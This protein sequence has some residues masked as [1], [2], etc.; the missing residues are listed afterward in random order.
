MREVGLKRIVIDGLKPREITI[1]SLSKTL[2]SVSG[3]EEVSIVVTEV[4]TKTETVKLTITG[5]NIDYD[6]IVKA[7][8]ENSTIVRSIDEVTAAKIKSARTTT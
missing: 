2:C 5:S 8:S 7:M 6:S 4:D 1:V 3:V